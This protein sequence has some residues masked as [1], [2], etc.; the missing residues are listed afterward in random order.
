MRQKT[1]LIGFY[2]DPEM[3]KRIKEI[4]KSRGMS[5]STFIRYIISEVFFYLNYKKW[6]GYVKNEQEMFKEIAED[7]KRIPVEEPKADKTE[8]AERGATK[9]SGGND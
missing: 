9:T 7:V 3:E 8:I 2:V 4:A 5:V 6:Y 1:K